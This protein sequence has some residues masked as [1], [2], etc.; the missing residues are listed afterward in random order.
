MTKATAERIG[1]P[2]DEFIRDRVSQIPVARSGKPEDIA[3][4]VAFFADER[5]SFVNGQ[6][7]YIAGGPKA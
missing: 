7:L 6:V 2:F 1:V 4:A 5:S 3:N